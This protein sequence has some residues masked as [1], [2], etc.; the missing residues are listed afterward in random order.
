[1]SNAKELTAK[2][3]DDLL[4]TLRARFEANLRR[5]PALEWTD[6][7]YDTV[8]VFHNGGESYYAAR[9]FRCSLTS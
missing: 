8:F 4:R 9:G 1:M 2:Q 6:R 3:R 7:R 5:H